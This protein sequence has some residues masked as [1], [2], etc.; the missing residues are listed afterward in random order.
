MPAAAAEPRPVGPI[1]L[2]VGLS[3]SR[4]LILW[5][6]RET[7]A[8]AVRAT[9]AHDASPAILSWTSDVSI[10]LDRR[11]S[12]GRLPRGDVFE[13]PALLGRRSRARDI[14]PRSGRDGRCR[15]ACRVS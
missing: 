2:V 14:D 13:P 9:G 7:T 6:D 15:C 3:N 11:F 5:I 10:V 1:L 8:I 4:I 12:A